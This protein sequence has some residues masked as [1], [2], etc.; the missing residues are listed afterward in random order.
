MDRYDIRF[1]D[2]KKHGTGASARFRGRWALD[3]HEHHRSFKDRTLADNFLDALKDAARDRRPF[4][5]VTGLPED[6]APEQE[7]Q[8]EPVSWYEHARAYAEAKWDHLAPVSRRSVA[9]ALVTVT[10]ALTTRQKGAP[11]AKVLRQALFSWAFNPASRDTSPPP[12][13]EAALDWAARASL[14]VTALDDST[15]TRKA[16]TACGKKLDGKAAAATTQRRKRSVLYNALGYA[17]ELGHLRSNPVNRIQWTAPEAAQSVNRRVVVSPDQAA[18]LLAAVRG[19]GERGEHLEAFFGCLYYAALRPSEGV[20]LREGDL[21]LPG[22]GWGR[23]D[24]AASASRAGTAWTD[25]GTARQERGLKH[26]AATET[27]SIPV[28][29]VLVAL[30]RAHL[31]RYGTAPDRAAVPDRP[32]RPAAELRLQRG[33]GQSPENRA[34]P[35]PVPPSAGAAPV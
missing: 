32:G 1:W 2:I 12:P 29:P 17:V 24:L 4:S 34:D 33:L 21:H 18:A 16:L 11:E 13:V 15:V 28:P 19:Q 30:L 9:E 25:E 35:G 3:G 5:P 23:I 26:R 8:A 20:M 27:R 7:E 31:K 6:E 22:K 14:P 10:V